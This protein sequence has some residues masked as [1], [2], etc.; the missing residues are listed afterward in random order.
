MWICCIIFRNASYHK[1][2]HRRRMLVADGSVAVADRFRNSL[3]AYSRHEHR[4]VFYRFIYTGTT[5]NNVKTCSLFIRLQMVYYICSESYQKTKK[6]KWKKSF[7]LPSWSLPALLCWVPADQAEKPAALWQRI[8]CTKPSFHE[9]DRI[10]RTLPITNHQRKI[11]GKTTGD[12]QT[13]H[14]LLYQQCGQKPAGKE[15]S[16]CERGFLFSWSHQTPFYLG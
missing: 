6:V 2:Q 3:W 8:S 1:K 15:C 11:C 7:L 14:P 12:L 9:L 4:R 13:Q 5:E 10:N 16:A